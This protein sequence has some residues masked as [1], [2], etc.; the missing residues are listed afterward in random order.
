MYLGLIGLCDCEPPA[1]LVG[2]VRSSSIL[3]WGVCGDLMSLSPLPLC[4]GL[5]PLAVTGL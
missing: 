5:P 4:A 3:S 2:V 1:E